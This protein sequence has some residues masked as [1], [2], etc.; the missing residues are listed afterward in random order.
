MIWDSYLIN[1]CKDIH[2]KITT[3]LPYATWNDEWRNYY[4]WCYACS[5]MYQRPYLKKINNNAWTKQKK[6]NQEKEKE[7][8]V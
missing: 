2:T 1:K 5:L 4:Y 3:I 8:G 6:K 7:E